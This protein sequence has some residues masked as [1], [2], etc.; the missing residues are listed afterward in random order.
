MSIL[1]NKLPGAHPWIIARDKKLTDEQA[2]ILSKLSIMI[3][4]PMYGGQCMGTFASSV[5]DL[6]INLHSLGIK[7]GK[8]YLYNESLIQRGRNTL[9]AMYEKGD[10]DYLLFIDADIGFEP[11]QVLEMLLCAHYTKSNFMGGSYPLK[12]INWQGI[13]KAIAAGV[14]DEHLHHCAGQHVVRFKEQNTTLTDFLAPIEVRYLA[15]G[16]MLIHKSVL[17]AIR[18]TEYA[19]KLNQAMPGMTL[20][21]IVYAY[22]DCKI[23]EQA[24]YLS[25]DYLFSKRCVDAGLKP[26]LCPWI[27]LTHSGTIVFGG[28][29]CCSAGAY[30]HNIGAK[31]GE[32]K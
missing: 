8:Q 9:T 12:T 2:Q 5:T 20:G 18:K 14:P 7:F 25:E 11:H 21:E 1:K 23:D 31:Q 28:C 19:Y 26:M 6:C 22:F 3:A 17:D 16:F 10:Y 32:Q 13:R 29:L 30:A 4:V 24:E 27:Y 15:T